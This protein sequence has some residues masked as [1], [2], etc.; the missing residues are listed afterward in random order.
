MTLAFL[1][2]LIEFA[3][4][5]LVAAQD[6]DEPESV[7]FGLNEYKGSGSLGSSTVTA[8][9]D[10]V[11]VSS[12][13]TGEMVAGDHPTHIHTGMCEDFG[14][15]PSFLLNTVVLD[16]VANE[17]ASAGLMREGKRKKGSFAR[18]GVLDAPVPHKG[19][20]RAVYGVR[21]PHRHAH[22]SGR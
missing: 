10:E 18:I 11:V 6:E 13:I 14:S 19:A 21:G 2:A 20:R 22:R 3:G 8:Q 5:V 7:T 16:P 12:Q 15:D 9:G 1:L 4:V 17:S